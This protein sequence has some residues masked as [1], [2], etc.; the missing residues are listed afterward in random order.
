MG[1]FWLPSSQAPLSW[2]VFLLYLLSSVCWSSMTCLL[3]QA[4]TLRKMPLLPDC[5]ISAGRGLKRVAS[6]REYSVLPLKRHMCIYLWPVSPSFRKEFCFSPSVQITKWIPL[7]EYYCLCLLYVRG[8]LLLHVWGLV[9]T[10]QGTSTNYLQLQGD[11]VVECEMW[12][13]GHE[14]IV[15]VTRNTWGP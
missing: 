7:W 4:G 2:L 12:G 3:F 15:E 11:G 5:I 6:Q 14:A 1:T 8:F 13:L 10:Q 9:A